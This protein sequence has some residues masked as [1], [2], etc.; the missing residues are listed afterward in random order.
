M[1]F[2][3]NKST[4]FYISS[5]LLVIMMWA[6]KSCTSFCFVFC[7]L[8][9]SRAAHCWIIFEVVKILLCSQC[10]SFVP[11]SCLLMPSC[12]SSHILPHV[13]V[14]IC[15]TVTFPKNYDCLYLVYNACI[16]NLYYPSTIGLLLFALWQSLLMWIL[17]YLDDSLT[18]SDL[19]RPKAV[20]CGHSFIR[21]L[22]SIIGQ[23]PGRWRTLT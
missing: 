22:R 23:N 15:I 5:F 19:N 8:D 13:F 12:Q 6:V 14:I 4:I 3:S 2:F 21:H 10:L 9:A 17:C 18:M 20:V 11:A 16:V 7:Q 1:Q